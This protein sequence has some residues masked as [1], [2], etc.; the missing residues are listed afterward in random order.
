MLDNVGCRMSNVGLRLPDCVSR[1]GLGI[2]DC[3]NKDFVLRI[4]KIKKN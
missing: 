1:Q 3:A 2:A 4:V